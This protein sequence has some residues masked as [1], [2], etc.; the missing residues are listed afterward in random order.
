VYKHVSANVNLTGTITFS[1]EPNLYQKILNSLAET[2]Q[3]SRATPDDLRRALL[4]CPPLE[5]I[6]LEGLVEAEE[7]H[8]GVIVSFVC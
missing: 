8:A 2:V 4:Q 7:Q 3:E 5:G 1:I 6:Q